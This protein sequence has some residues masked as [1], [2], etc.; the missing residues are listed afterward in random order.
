M[1]KNE[2]LHLKFKCTFVLEIYFGLIFDQKPRFFM[3]NYDFSASMKLFK[4][5]CT[6]A[7]VLLF[8]FI[9]CSKHNL[10]PFQ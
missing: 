1:Q 9:L 10:S 2:N 7:K 5:C 3:K 4:L 8:D 6:F